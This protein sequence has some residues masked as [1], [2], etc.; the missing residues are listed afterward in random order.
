M[1]VFDALWF[2]YIFLPWCAAKAGLVYSK[3]HPA[4]FAKPDDASR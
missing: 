2:R 4:G 3:R 1:N